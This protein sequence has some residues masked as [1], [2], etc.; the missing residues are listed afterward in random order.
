MITTTPNNFFAEDKHGP[1][2]STDLLDPGHTVKKLAKQ[3]QDHEAV[4]RSLSAGEHRRSLTR[5]QKRFLAAVAASALTL[6]IAG[7]TGGVD[8]EDTVPYKIQPG[9][10]AWDVARSSSQ[11]GDMRPLVDDIQ[12]QVG[13]EGMR[14]G[15]TVTI[16]GP[17]DQADQE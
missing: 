1:I 10:T 6:T 14:P 13:E 17:L 2:G 3:A 7:N 5:G 11:T 12:R 16:P 9:D 15:A 8:S 4:G